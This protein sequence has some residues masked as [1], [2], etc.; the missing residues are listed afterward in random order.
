[1]K[2]LMTRTGREPSQSNKGVAKL[3]RGLAGEIWQRRVA[4]FPFLFT[5]LMFC[6]QIFSSRLK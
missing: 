4:S 1:M 3:W 2:C 5:E 6:S